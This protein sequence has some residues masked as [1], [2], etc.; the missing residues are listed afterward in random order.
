M[1]SLLLHWTSCILRIFSLVRFLLSKFPL[2]G[3][4]TMQRIWFYLAASFA[5]ISSI[6]SLSHCCWNSLPHSPNFYTLGPGYMHS[7]KLIYLWNFQS[8]LFCPQAA[9]N[10][11]VFFLFLLPWIIS[12]FCLFLSLLISSS[13]HTYSLGA[14][15]ST[16]VCPQMYNFFYFKI[17]YPSK[18]CVM[19]WF[20]FQEWAWGKAFCL[21]H[22]VEKDQVSCIRYHPCF[23]Q[24]ARLKAKRFRKSMPPCNF[25]LPPVY[26]FGEKLVLHLLECWQGC[27]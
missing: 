25:D 19:S 18:V 13:T 24:K 7:L 17:A 14:L 20:C 16:S 9:W 5:K 10:T 3:W 26:N 2:V 8:K 22:F 15:S 6:A 4:H 27:F 11:T 23:A 12:V 1:H 21:E